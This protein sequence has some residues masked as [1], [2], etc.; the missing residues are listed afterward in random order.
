MLSRQVES[1]R[2]GRRYASWTPL[3]PFIGVV[4]G[5]GGGRRCRRDQTLLPLRACCNI[6]FGMRP[7]TPRTAKSFVFI[8]THVLIIEFFAY[9][10][11]ATETIGMFSSDKARLLRIVDLKGLYFCGGETSGAKSRLKDCVSA[12]VTQRSERYLFLTQ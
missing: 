1:G 4:D 5:G 3:D 10:I 12:L 2:Q 9:L 11:V 6:F 7:R 8:Y